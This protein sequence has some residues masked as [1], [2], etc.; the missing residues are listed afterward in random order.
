MLRWKLFRSKWLALF[1][2]A[3]MCTLFFL[4]GSDIPHEDWM[5]GLP[6]DKVVHVGLFC[7]LLFLWR[8]AFPARTAHYGLWL[9]VIAMLYGLAVEFVQK[10]WIPNRDFDLF[11]VLADTVGA[12][13]GLLIWR[14]VYKKNKPL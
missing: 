2:L 6:I 7:V 11:D 14:Q 1:W 8:S 4:P 12:V 3:L 13:A 5:N 10:E 9:L